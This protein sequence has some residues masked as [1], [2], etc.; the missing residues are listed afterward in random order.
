MHTKPT[1]SFCFHFSPLINTALNINFKTHLIGWLPHIAL[2]NSNNGNC[3]GWGIKGI[4]IL[5]RA[6]IVFKKGLIYNIKKNCTP[7]LWNY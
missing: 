5:K 1:L 4:R 2:D 7:I 6:F 3:N